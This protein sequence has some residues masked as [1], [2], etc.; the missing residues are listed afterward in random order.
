MVEEPQLVRRL[1]HICVLVT[2]SVACLSLPPAAGEE[3]VLTSSGYD[4]IN[5]YGMDQPEL[6]A[7]LTDGGS[8]ITEG[9]SPVI[10]EMFVDTGA[11]GTVISYLNAEGY[12]YEPFPGVL[13]VPL[14]T[15]GRHYVVGKPVG[16]GCIQDGGILQEDVF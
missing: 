5:A 15:A 4:Y 8:V 9:G 2:A 3:I 1:R 7:V 16:Q 13:A 6:N 14:S 10:I 11:S 12:D